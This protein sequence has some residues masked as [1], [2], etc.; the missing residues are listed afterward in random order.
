MKVLTHWPRYIDTAV[1]PEFGEGTSFTA[2]AEQAAPAAWSAKGSIV[3]PKMPTVG[4]AE[5][6]DDAAKE[7]KLE[8]IVMMPKILSP[9][10]QICRR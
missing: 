6:K 3:V 10:R 9:P 8:K 5:A 4:P 1:V 2:E 7:P